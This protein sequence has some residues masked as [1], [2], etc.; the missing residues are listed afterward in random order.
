[1]SA[2]ELDELDYAILAQLQEDGRRPF[3]EI[4]QTLAVSSSTIANRYQ[5][6]LAEGY[7]RIYAHVDPYRVG[8]GSPAFIGVKV[9]PGK[10]QQAAAELARLPEAD[11][12]AIVS[13]RY[14]VDV[15]VSCRDHQHLLEVIAQ[16]HAIDGVVDTQST[17]ILKMIKYRQ[18]SVSLIDNANRR[19]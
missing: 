18:A 3:K 16:I 15:T 7:V 2:P 14:D 17:I 12:V 19:P 11:Y 6:L 8:F 13:G 9:S 10:L 1:M 4:A 5:R